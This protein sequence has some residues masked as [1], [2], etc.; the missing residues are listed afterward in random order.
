MSWPATIILTPLSI[1]FALQYFQIYLWK[2]VFIMLVSS[3]LLSPFIISFSLVSL[4]PWFWGQD[5]IRFFSWLSPV[6]FLDP[7]SS[8][9]YSHTLR[10]LL[11][12]P[13]LSW[14]VSPY[15]M[16]ITPTSIPLFQVFSWLS[17]LHILLLFN[18]SIWILHQQLK[19]NMPKTEL[20]I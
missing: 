1:D 10:P 6:S 9:S 2:L 11:F 5:F 13:S 7:C 17:V 18:K 15:L 8:P 3:H 12:S 16:L 14:V 4:L 19:A 20:I